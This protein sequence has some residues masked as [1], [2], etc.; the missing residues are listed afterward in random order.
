MP[1]VDSVLLTAVLIDG[2]ALLE[3]RPLVD[4]Q[5]LQ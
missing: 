5:N 4:V 1:F 3:N 2:Q